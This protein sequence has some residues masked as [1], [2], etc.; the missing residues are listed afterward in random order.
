[1]NN[2]HT[3]TA[4]C[5]H[6]SGTVDDYCRAARAAGVAV[7]GMSD[8]CPL[9]DNRWDHVRMA[10]CELPCYC[11]ELN[12]ARDAYPDLT[13]LRAMECDYARE[14]LGFFENELLGARGMDYLVGAVHWFPKDGDWS[15]SHAGGLTRDPAF[16]AAYAAQYV[17]AITSGR[18]AFMAHPDLFG[19]FH[20]CW[21]A[22]AEQAARDILAAA[23]ETRTPLE[24]NGLGFRK[25]T[26][27]S[28]EGLRH[29]YPWRPFWELA[30]DYDVLVVANSDAHKPDDVLASI[31]DCHALAAACGLTVSEPHL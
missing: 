1:M 23:A 30:A 11:D 22:A 13:I 25:R 31:P 26:V 14:Y 16:I 2:Y 7:L 17:E 28:S 3:H 27:A 20:D 5:R 21:D 4:R 18:F 6:A 8:H 9:P 19:M 24:I 15:S 10:M 29:V 12:R